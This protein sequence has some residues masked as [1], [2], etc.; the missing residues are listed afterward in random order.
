MV[1]LERSAGD[2]AEGKMKVIV[3]L[4]L[5]RNLWFSFRWPHGL[6]WPR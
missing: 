3:A 2:V 5:A 4:Y 6:V 1:M